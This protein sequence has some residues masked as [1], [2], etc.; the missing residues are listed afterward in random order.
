MTLDDLKDHW[1][2][3]G[4]LLKKYGAQL[5]EAS[6]L[7]V[8]FQGR[9]NDLMSWLTDV[10]KH[11]NNLTP[12]SRVFN[13]VAQQKEDHKVCSLLKHSLSIL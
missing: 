13:V 5:L 6:Q 11:L 1:R 4:D 10:E 2:Q 7:S 12:V 8:D 3:V 9:L